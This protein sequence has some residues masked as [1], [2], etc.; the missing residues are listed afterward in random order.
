MQNPDPEKLREFIETCKEWDI[1]DSF[2]EMI[3]KWQEATDKPIRTISRYFETSSAVTKWWRDGQ[4]VPPEGTQ[5]LVVHHLQES[6]ESILE[7]LETNLEDVIQRLRGIGYDPIE[8]GNGAD[9]HDKPYVLME[10]PPASLVGDTKRLW[11][12]CEHHG[13]EA[14]PA[15]EGDVWIQAT[16]DP[17]EGTPLIELVGVTDEMLED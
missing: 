15:G 5:T 3:K 8:K 1:G 2:G 9:D 16:F 12:W 4:M 7:E 14:G 6:A 17:A 13:I 10:A 11:K